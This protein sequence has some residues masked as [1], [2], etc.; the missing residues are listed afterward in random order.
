M[1]NVMSTD[2]K[3]GKKPA[4]YPDLGEGRYRNPVLFADYSDPDAVRFGDAFYMTASSFSSTPGLPILESFDLVNWTI[5]GHAVERLPEAY[6]RVRHGCGVWAPSIR[7]HDG[8]LWIY[9][10]DPDMGI[11]MTTARHPAGPWTPLHLVKAAKGWIDPCPLWDEGG[12]AYLV[13]AFANSRSRIKSKLQICRMSPDGR[14]LLDEGTLVFDGTLHHPTIEG[15]KLYKRNGFYYIFAPAGG[16]PTG[17]QTVLRSTNILGPYEDRIVLHQGATDVNGPHQGAFVELDSGESWFLH[18]QD[19]GAYGRVVHLQ[20][21]E[22][23]EDWPVIGRDDDGD[24]IGEPVPVC[25]KPD[26]GQAGEFAVPATDDEFEGGRLGLQWQWQANGK[27]EWYSLSE[28]PGWLRLYAHPLPD[29]AATLYDAPQLLCQKLPAPVF[30]ASAYLA[31]DPGAA[32]AGGACRAGL[33]V[34]G[35]RYAYLALETGAGGVL[36]VYAEGSGGSGAAPEEKVLEVLEL[37][38]RA[39]AVYL[40]VVVEEGASCTFRYSFDGAEYHPFGRLFAAAEG[41]WT[42]A[43]LGLFCLGEGSAPGAGPGWADFDWFRVDGEPASAPNC[44]DPLDFS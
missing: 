13:H 5:V 10:A 26:T 11:Y 22:W 1:K 6:D 33:A 20:P 15:P 8:R 4:W 35:H 3:Y 41:G 37:N 2:T 7:H 30:C 9:F 28:R 38:G 29:G 16:V 17:W 25:R 21:M 32:G 19:K 34:F 18:F 23:M 12:Q 44:S 14:S 43:K 36:L 39:A 40:R 27:P 24:G 42:G 31:L